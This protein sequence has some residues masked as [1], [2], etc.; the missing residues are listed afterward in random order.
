MLIIMWLAKTIRA[1][2]P[3][4]SPQQMNSSIEYKRAKAPIAK[5]SVLNLFSTQTL[6]SHK[7]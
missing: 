2:N 5:S 6:R 3:S 7:S 4:I 1:N